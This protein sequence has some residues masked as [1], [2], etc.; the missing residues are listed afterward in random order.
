MRGSCE[1]DRGSAVWTPRGFHMRAPPVKPSVERPRRRSGG[2]L[3][4][5][6]RVAP[7]RSAP[8]SVRPMGAPAWPDAS[9]PAT[10]PAC[11]AR[12]CP[13]A[14]AAPPPTS[15][16]PRHGPAARRRHRRAR[17]RAA[18]AR[19]GAPGPIGAARLRLAIGRDGIGLE[20]AE[21]VDLGCL[22]VIEL[23]T[24][25]P[26]MRFPGRRLRRRHPLPPSAR[27]PPD[28]ARRG[29]RA[30]RRAM[31]GA[32]GSAGSSAHA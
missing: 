21:P 30:R 6:R 23:S 19:D 24:T 4:G 2:P 27:G 12:A 13:H 25:L 1:W 5:S 31:D 28:P 18:G 16:R 17:G 10:M 9:A 22:R 29:R 3:G 26:G 14:P 15:R 32:S 11:P 20:L 7:R 8:R